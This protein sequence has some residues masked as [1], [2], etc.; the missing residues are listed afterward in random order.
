M[1][2]STPLIGPAGPH[3]GLSVVNRIAASKGFRGFGWSTYLTILL[4]F[5][6]GFV[7]F[8]HH[9]F[10]F[11]QFPYHSRVGRIGYYL[12]V[13][14]GLIFFFAAAYQ[15]VSPLRR[16]W[17]TIHH[18]VGYIFTVAQVISTI[19][20][21]TILFSGSA[22]AGPNGAAFSF[23][24][25][26]WWVL[27]LFRAIQA[28]IRRDI[29]THNIW[30][31]RNVFYAFGIIW[32]RPGVLINTAIVPGLPIEYALGI[33]LV[34]VMIFWFGIGE[35]WIYLKY[36]E[37]IFK[38]RYSSVI[39]NA[40]FPA[41]ARSTASYIPLPHDTTA[42]EDATTIYIPSSGNDSATAD[43]A[44]LIGPYPP[45]ILAPWTPITLTSKTSL[46]DRAVLLRFHMATNQYPVIIPPGRH[47]T[48]RAKGTS[49]GVRSYTP[50]SNPTETAYGNFDFLISVRE[51]GGPKSMSKYISN[52]QLGQTMEMTPSQGSFNVPT[53]QPNLLLI[54]GGSGITPILS[55][56]TQL[57]PSTTPPN[58]TLLYT[59]K[60]SPPPL[61]DH[62]RALADRYSSFTYIPMLKLKQQDVVDHLPD[63]ETAKEVLQTEKGREQWTGEK[64]CVLVSGPPGLPKSVIKWVGESGF[65]RELIWAFDIDGR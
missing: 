5:T 26:C 1:T 46:S 53:S 62:L 33:T 7:I 45:R 3:R 13:I 38:S 17:P 54:A 27:T 47:V 42:K 50:I 52:L 32:T 34:W 51:N 24:A 43:N 15:F 41:R 40:I 30:I 29:T 57:L 63:L 48:L 61:D 35:W 6:G 60:T 4:A 55:V 31:I 49:L 56:L 59:A 10:R 16:L 37:G 23:F 44:P 65:A 19:G 8:L 12:H 22:E 25:V 18:Y 20:I 64:A 2:V 36:G 28:A 21:L 58:I 39:T 9:I 14:P 11:S